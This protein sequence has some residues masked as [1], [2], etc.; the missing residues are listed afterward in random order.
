E[1]YANATGFASGAARLFGFDGAEWGS[2]VRIVGPLA[3]D[4]A[5]FGFAVALDATTAL[6]GAPDADPSGLSSGA[7]FAFDAAPAECPSLI[8]DAACPDGGVGTIAWSGATPGGSVAVVYAATEGAVVIPD[9][10]PCAGTMLALGG[11]GIRLVFQGVSDDTGSGSS[12]AR[13]AAGVGRA[14]V[15]LIDLATCRTSPIVTIE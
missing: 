1:P 14:L 6:V 9:G 5:H 11:E 12:Q 13:H 7:A 3:D 8:V 2:G 10:S 15:Q 4:R